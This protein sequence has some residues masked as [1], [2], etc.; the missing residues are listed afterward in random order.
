MSSE[1]KNIVIVGGDIHAWTIATGLLVGVGKH[2]TISVIDDAPTELPGVT[3]LDI[4]AH[5][6]HRKLGLKEQALVA[7]LGGAYCLGNSYTGSEN[8]ES[9]YTY[10]P[11]GE[12]LNRV[13][14]HDYVG[15]LRD[16]NKEVFF[17]DYSIAAVAAKEN[18]FTHP[19]PDTP[20]K[21]LDYAMQLDT[22]RYKHFLR[23]SALANGV[24]HILSTVKSVSLDE[25]GNTKKI[26]LN[27]NDEIDCDFIFDCLGSLNSDQEMAAF[28][29]LSNTILEDRQ[30]AW[31]RETKSPTPILR[32]CEKHPQGWLQRSFLPG[33]EYLR[34]S[35]DS[36]N[37]S[38]EDIHSYVQGL[39]GLI[40]AGLSEFSSNKPGFNLTPWHGNVLSIGKAAGYVGNFLFNDLFH[41]HTALE[42]W[43]RMYPSKVGSALLAQEYNRCAQM[44][45]EHVHD[46]HCLIT[47]VAKEALP[48]T[49]KHRISLFKSTGRVAFYESDVLEKHQWVNL[50]IESG[51]WP[52]R[53]DPMLNTLSMEKLRLQL[54]DIAVRNKKIAQSFPEHDQLLQAI[55]QLPKQ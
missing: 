11:V 6:F 26:V 35:F 15:R 41:T 30:L 14:F 51:I 47:G 52:D 4:P 2:V 16:T 38:D 27:S 1:I 49:L 29:D 24:E 32:R 48:Q 9:V 19:Q 37:S 23:S 12:M 34:F 22:L 53:S 55:R 25:L 3:S 54:S 8:R 40:P 43:L 18:R 20:F 33:G 10:S 13:E 45:Y 5:V 31:V 39:L 36:S 17:G 46:V 44:E 28:R 42:R 21:N 50:M 7:N